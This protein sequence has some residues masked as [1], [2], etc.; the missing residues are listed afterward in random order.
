M[1]NKE[2]LI[3]VLNNGDQLLASAIEHEGV[4]VC[5]DVLQILTKVDD[6]DRMSM[7]MVPYL[8]FSDSAGGL[9]IPTNMAIIAIPN[10][11]LKTHYQKQFSRII[12]PQASKII[13]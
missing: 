7:G 13:L 8:P 4:Y 11:E 10:A 2:I 5:S 3:L 6:S 1:D 9:A 12:T